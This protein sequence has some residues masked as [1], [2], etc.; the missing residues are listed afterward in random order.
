VYKA[1]VDEA[2]SIV[3]VYVVI[4]ETQG[5]ALIKFGDLYVAVDVA[6][7]ER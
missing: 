3:F 4:L 5:P 2:E 7:D 6:E 1:D